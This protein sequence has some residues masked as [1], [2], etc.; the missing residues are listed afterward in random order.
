MQEA[1]G[2]AARFT[3]C[4]VIDDHT[5]AVL[6]VIAALLTTHPNRRLENTDWLETLSSIETQQTEVYGK[7]TSLRVCHVSRHEV[8]YGLTLPQLIGTMSLASAHPS[9]RVRFEITQYI[10]QCLIWSQ[11]CQQMNVILCS[12]DRQ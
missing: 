5:P 6:I 11:L 3:F 1:T 7:L 12:I 10:R 4:V 2:A 9:A 8:E